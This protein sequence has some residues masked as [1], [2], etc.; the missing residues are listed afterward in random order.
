MF[1]K[2]PVNSCLGSG[3]VGF[4]GW[5]QDRLGN[6]H[7]VCRDT[8]STEISKGGGYE[9]EVGCLKMGLVLGDSVIF[10]KKWLEVISNKSKNKEC[11]KVSRFLFAP[12]PKRTELLCI[13][14][15]EKETLNLRAPHKFLETQIF[16]SLQFFNRKNLGWFICPASN[17][18]IDL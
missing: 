10:G 4:F 12:P 18:S 17:A 14:Q 6:T 7:L 13:L 2:L 3:W 8:T 9:V 11:R 1:R 15:W 5:S 16:G